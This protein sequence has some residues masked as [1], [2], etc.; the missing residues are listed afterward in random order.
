MTTIHQA[1]VTY[2]D[3]SEG[4]FFSTDGQWFYEHHL[5]EKNRKFTP[6]RY[7]R[8]FLKSCARSSTVSSVE[9]VETE[10]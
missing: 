2:A 9:F 3:G 7:E 6:M 10:A 4:K 5:P 8:G 1:T